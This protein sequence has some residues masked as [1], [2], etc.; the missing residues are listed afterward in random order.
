MFF[1]FVIWNINFVC[2]WELIVLK[3]L[4]EEVLDVLCLQECK[5]FVEKILI[6]GFVV[7]GYVYMVVCGQKGYNGVVILLKILMVDVGDKDFVNLGYVCYVVGKFENGVMVQ[8]F[9]VFVGGDELNCEKNEKFG[10]KF[11]YLIDMCDWFYVEKFE[12][13]IFVGDLNIVL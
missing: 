11:D 13:L 3:F 1:I 5:S 8:N 4:E 9:Y 7:F 10:Q 6:E 12:K 2:F